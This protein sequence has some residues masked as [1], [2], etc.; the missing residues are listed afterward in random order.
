MR[1]NDFGCDKGCE[2]DQNS[3]FLGKMRVRALLRLDELFNW[4][5]KENLRTYVLKTP[6][7]TVAMHAVIPELKTFEVHYGYF[8]PSHPLISRVSQGS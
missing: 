3:T 4:T 6:L 5:T 7:N 2:I 8:S 1:S